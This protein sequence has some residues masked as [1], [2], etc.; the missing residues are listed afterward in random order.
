MARMINHGAKIGKEYYITYLFKK[1]KSPIRAIT[2]VYMYNKGCDGRLHD[3]NIDISSGLLDLV[4]STVRF[5]N[6]FVQDNEFAP[7]LD[8]SNLAEI[9]RFYAVLQQEETPV[10]VFK[11]ATAFSEYLFK[12]D[13]MMENIKVEI[14]S[15]MWYHLSTQTV[16]EDV[17]GSLENIYDITFKYKLADLFYQEVLKSYG[18]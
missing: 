5:L 9:N 10:G 13:A 4:L 11:H 14:K 2:D 6:D 17:L 12:I 8:T 16:T 15:L 18:E 1:N 7:K 3:T